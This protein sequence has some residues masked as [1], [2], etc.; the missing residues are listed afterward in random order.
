METKHTPG[1][2]T[3]K[4]FKEYPFDILTVNSKDE[5]VFRTKLPAHCTSDKTFEQAFKCVHF[6]IDEDREK[7]IE[8]NE[9]ALADEKLRAAAPELLQFAIEMARRYPNSPWINEEA[10]KLIEKATK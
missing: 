1:P 6:G 5:V 9:R 2:L 3:V 10:N 4:P 8:A 7:C